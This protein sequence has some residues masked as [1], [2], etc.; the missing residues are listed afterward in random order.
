MSALWGNDF[1]CRLKCAKCATSASTCSH[2]GAADC[3]LCAFYATAANVYTAVATCEARDSSVYA[4]TAACETGDS[5]VY[6]TT[7]ACEAGDSN[8]YTACT[9]SVYATNSKK[10]RAATCCTGVL[11]SIAADTVGPQCADYFCYTVFCITADGT[12]LRTTGD[13]GTACKTSTQS[14]NCTGH[15]K[16]G[17][18]ATTEAASA[19]TV[20]YPIESGSAVCI[21]Q[22]GRAVRHSFIVPSPGSR[23]SGACGRTVGGKLNGYSLGFAYL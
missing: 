12:L 14:D 8:I 2:A 21:C 16:A 6:A 5:S 10:T 11:Y 18:S 15:A 22:P 7:A 9:A 4:T 23:S 1:F 20:L 13:T 17:A 3:D 19:E